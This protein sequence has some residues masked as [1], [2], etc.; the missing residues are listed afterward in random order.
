M[1]RVIEEEPVGIGETSGALDLLAWVGAFRTEGFDLLDALT[2]R[3]TRTRGSS[4]L[5]EAM[6]EMQNLV[7]ALGDIECLLSQPPPQVARPQ[8]T[9]AEG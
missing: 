4:G 7:N 3:S 2:R 6:T 8:L 5:P 1:A 9:P